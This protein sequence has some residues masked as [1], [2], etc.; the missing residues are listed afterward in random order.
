MNHF[1]KC[2]FSAKFGSDISC[3]TKTISSGNITLVK[4][5]SLVSNRGRSQNCQNLNFL[6]IFVARLQE[7][8]L[9]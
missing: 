8:H 6:H 4:A 7:A 3:G 1:T 9:P 5:Y 2:L